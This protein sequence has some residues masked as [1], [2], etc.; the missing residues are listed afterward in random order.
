ML[1]NPKFDLIKWH[2]DYLSENNLFHKQYQQLHR[3]TYDPTCME[4]DNEFVRI[5]SLVYVESTEILEWITCTL[6]KCQPFL[7]DNISVD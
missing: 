1:E 6:E 3:Q 2:L 4:E 7:G 5:P